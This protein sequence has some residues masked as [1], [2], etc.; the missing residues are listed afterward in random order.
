MDR[1]A[2]LPFSPPLLGFRF[3]VFFFTGGGTQANTFDIL[4]QKVSGIG[5]TVKTSRQEE[6][7]QNLF[8][9]QLPDR[10]EHDNLVLERGL[11]VTSPLTTQF[12]ETLTQFRFAPADV[13]VTLLNEA[14]R[15]L[16]SWKFLQAYPVRWSIGD[17]DAQSNTIVIERLELAYQ[18]M[19]PIGL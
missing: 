10:I 14:N 5:A 17:L 18:H 19:Q 9:Q 7:G 16:L 1:P 6:G 13:L 4:F 3:D 12:L 11:M 2:P 15:A 8:V